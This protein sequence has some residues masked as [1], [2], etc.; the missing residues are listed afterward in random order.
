[1][2]SGGKAIPRP[3]ELDLEFFQAVV[4]GGSVHVQRCSKCSHIHHPPRVY[5]PN[6]F[7]ADY[8]FVPV[9]GRGA[10]YSHTVSHFTTEKAWM[11][12]VPYATVVVE[13]AE[14]PRLVASARG[15]DHTQLRIGLP[16]RV[17]SE[18]VTDDFA[19]LWA[20]PD[21]DGERERTR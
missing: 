21:A 19:Y 14:G 5:C 4:N 15:I 17:V 18:P 1:M 20:E 9:S 10:V 8:T 3:S 7:S 12:S 2:S 11:D 6:C 16:V 13:L